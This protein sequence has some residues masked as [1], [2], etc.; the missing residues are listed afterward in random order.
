MSIFYTKQK[1]N[2]PDDTQSGGGGIISACQRAC[3]QCVIQH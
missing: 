1:D 2:V 3:F